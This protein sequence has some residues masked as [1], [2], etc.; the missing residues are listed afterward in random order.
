MKI[1]K[2]TKTEEVYVCETCGDCCRDEVKRYI[3]TEIH[4]SICESC[5]DK[6]EDMIEAEIQKRKKERKHETENR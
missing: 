4:I 6:L 3:D 1:I 5:V 2:R